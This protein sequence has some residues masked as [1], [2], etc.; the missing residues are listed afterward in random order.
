M[1]KYPHQI[2]LDDINV[3]SITFDILVSAIFVLSLFNDFLT[4]FIEPSETELMETIEYDMDEQG[5]NNEKEGYV[6]VRY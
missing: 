3:L 1:K 5:K 4:P 6:V 2:I